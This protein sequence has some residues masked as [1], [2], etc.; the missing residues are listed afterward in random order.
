[1]GKI[2]CVIFDL[3][4]TLLNTVTTIT[5]YINVTLR[6]YSLP[7]VTEDECVGYV[8]NGAM[9]LVRRTLAA[10]GISDEG[11]IKEFHDRYSGTYDLSPYYLTAPYEGIKNLLSDLIARGIKLAVLSN[12]PDFA[13]RAVIDRFFPDTFLSV[14][15][16]RDGVALKPAPD[17]VRG[18]AEELSVELSD[19]AFVGDSEVDVQTGINSKV[20]L[21]IAVKWGFRK[22]DELISAG[23]EILADTPADVFNLIVSHS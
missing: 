20:G 3:D 7:T 18:I 5:H 11:T 2:N 17:G 22:P 14:H 19:C 6:E 10:R 21:N 1:M 15:G 8:G 4:G 12:K 9:M 23:A 16:G 13:T